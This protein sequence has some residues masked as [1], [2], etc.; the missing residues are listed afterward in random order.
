MAR[1]PSIF[2]LPD[3]EALERFSTLGVDLMFAEIKASLHDFGVAVSYTHLT[4]PTIYS[5]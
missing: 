4:L 2:D 3:P 1:E 5:V